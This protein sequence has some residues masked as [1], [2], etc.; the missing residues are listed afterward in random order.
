MASS[1]LSSGS[2]KCRYNKAS[3]F[4][5]LFLRIRKLIKK[6]KKEDFGDFATGSYQDV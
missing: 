5:E 3:N 4:K 1:N 2:A 6:I